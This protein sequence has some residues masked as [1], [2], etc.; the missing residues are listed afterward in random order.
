MDL[1]ALEDRK[2]SPY[3]GWTHDHWHEI[4]VLLVRGFFRYSTPGGAG[5]VYPGTHESIWSK[6]SERMEGFARSFFLSAPFLMHSAE[7]VIQ[8]ESETLNVAEFYR[9]G[10]MHGTDPKHPEYW[11]GI[12]SFSQTIVEGAALALNM[13]FSKR[14]V[15]DALSVSEQRNAAEY[16]LAVARCKTYRNN[17]MLFR[18]IIYAVLKAFGKPH[19][20][21]AMNR[22]AG[23]SA[24]LYVANGWYSDGRERSFD[25]YN[26]WVMHP[27]LLFWCDINPDTK[28]D[29]FAMCKERMNIFTSHLMHFFAADG[30]YPAYGRSLIYRTG[31]VSAFSAAEYFACSALSPGEARR[32]CSGNL[33][34]FWERG[35]IEEEGYFTLGYHSSL[36]E[37]AEYYSCHQSPLWAAKAWWSFLFT[38]EH[39]FWQSAE[40][41]LPVETKDYTRDITDTGMLVVGS[42]DSGQVMLSSVNQNSYIEKKYS[43]LYVLSHFGMLVSRNGYS[44]PFDNSVCTESTKG[45]YNLGRARSELIMSGSGFS[46]FG[47]RLGDVWP[48]RV[49]YT[50][51]IFKGEAVVRI[52]TTDFRKPGRFF[53]GG[54][55]LAYED[56]VFTVK[57]EKN[58]IEMNSGEQRVFLQSIYGWE[59]P[60]GTMEWNYGTFGNSI[61][62][63]YAAYPYL[64]TAEPVRGRKVFISLCVAR[65]EGK[66]LPNMDSFV[67]VVSCENGVVE[68]EFHDGERV[69][70]QPV[71]VQDIKRKLGG[72]DISGP[73]RFARIVPG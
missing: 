48:P 35:A 59:S 10:I 58:W 15:W 57:T 1:V 41:P 7:G 17:W 56:K 52:H 73:V 9:K 64:S 65:P 66:S 18:A 32:I 28:P 40:E 27:Y 55:A 22:L 37:V 12:R 62:G 6:N 53:E 47:R 54:V 42:K 68:L 51:L 61:N 2:I 72:V 13:Y 44:W 3:T 63:R 46:I 20:E 30:S 19:D 24:D 71:E 60:P 11:G 21:G 69:I 45:Q 38:K 36:P 5:I 67:S 23:R 14:L 39:P 25:Y 31:V 16:L 29:F 49:A 50:C 4:M 34:Y 26:A 33:K 8:L 43:N 70:L